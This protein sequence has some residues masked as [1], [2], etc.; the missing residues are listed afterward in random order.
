MQKAYISKIQATKMYK[1]CYNMD[2]KK[3]K[4]GN[5]SYDNVQNQRYLRHRK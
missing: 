2:I 3:Q 1:I 4:K 5:N